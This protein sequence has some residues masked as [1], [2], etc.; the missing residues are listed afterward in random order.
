MLFSGPDDF[1]LT[2]L[3]SMLALSNASAIY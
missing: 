1:G 3:C 2:G